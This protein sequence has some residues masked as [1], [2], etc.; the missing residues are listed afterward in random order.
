M[1]T[2]LLESLRLLIFGEIFKRL[3]LFDINI[4]DFNLLLL[5]FFAD[6]SVSIIHR[7]HMI[8]L[9]KEW[10]IFSISQIKRGLRLLNF[11][12]GYVYFRAYV[13]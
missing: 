2:L 12:Q 8:Y 4:F 10:F 7:E 1:P 5:N 9:Q 3:R 13:Y 6:F 11:S